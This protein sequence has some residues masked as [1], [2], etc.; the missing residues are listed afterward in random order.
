MIRTKSIEKKEPFIASWW[1]I[2]MCS[3]GF[4]VSIV[5]FVLASIGAPLVYYRENIQAFCDSRGIDLFE[6]LFSAICVVAGI[7]A[8]FV[9]A[10][11]VY[12]FLR[13][14]YI[15]AQ[16]VRKAPISK[17]EMTAI[18]AKTMMEKVLVMASF[19]LA[20]MAAGDH[21]GKRGWNLGYNGNEKYAELVKIE[22]LE[23]GKVIPELNTPRIRYVDV[24]ADFV[25]LSWG[26]HFYEKQS[27][28][29][30]RR[31]YGKWGTKDLADIANRAKA[32]ISK[33]VREWCIEAM[34][35]HLPLEEYKQEELRKIREGETTV[36][37]CLF[38][39]LFPELTI[40]A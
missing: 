12:D 20:P 23:P 30:C 6:R 1:S 5:G 27:Y 29:A 8:A 2:A 11:G 18:G 25:R 15:Q 26:A 31:L 4:R 38:A 10:W 36:E 13:H 19:M 3:R 14:V 22:R 34:Q 7:C 33:E 17:E 16:I 35:E 32:S 37:T 40:A 39:L 24:L 28:E 21:Q 9:L